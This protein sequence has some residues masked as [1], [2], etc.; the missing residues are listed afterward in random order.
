MVDGTCSKYK[1]NVFVSWFIPT[2]LQ[3]LFDTPNDFKKLVTSKEAWEVFEELNT[4]RKVEIQKMVMEL[5]ELMYEFEDRLGE[6]FYHPDGWQYFELQCLRRI[7]PFHNYYDGEILE[8]LSTFLT[9]W[10]TTTL[11]RQN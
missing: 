10:N 9:L 2:C 7:G 8:E 3:V 1:Y 5:M 11:Q 6:E 4:V